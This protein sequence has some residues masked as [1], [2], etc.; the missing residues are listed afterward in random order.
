MESLARSLT[1]QCDPG[2]HLRLAPRKGAAMV[3][4]ARLVCFSVLTALPVIGPVTTLHAQQRVIDRYDLYSGFTA[5]STPHLNLTE[6]GYN[7]QAGVNLRSWLAT[8]FDFAYVTGHSSLT[9][10]MLKPALAAQINQEIAALE[11]AQKLPPGYKLFVPTDS[12]TQTFAAGPQFS[13]RRWN[14]LTLFARPALGAVHQTATPH[15]N[16]ADPFALA[17]TQLLAPSGKKSDWQG[18]YG[19]GGGLDWNLT[20]HIALR[21]Q[22]D[23]VY[24][25]LFNDLLNGN[26]TVRYSVGP[27]IRFGGN[28]L[29]HHHR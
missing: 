20:E 28:I 8:G 25:T 9:P 3:R 18:F 6:R 22:M 17:V 12:S 16:P 27:T 1:S 2:S 7:F 11:A 26:W 14:Y 29:P 15:P 23:L 10:S 19:F 5:F 24:W 13:Y 4:F 21:T